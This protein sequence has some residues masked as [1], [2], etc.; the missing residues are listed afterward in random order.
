[1]TW[2]NNGLLRTLPEKDAA[3][4]RSR[5]ELVTLD[6]DQ[7][8]FESK[9]PI[10]N[11]YFFESGLSSEVVFATKS[12]EVG[13]IGHEGC[14]GVPVLLGVD[15]SPH[16]AFMQA[17]GTALRIASADLTELIDTNRAIRELLLRYAH[18][19]MIQIA[20]TALADGRYDIEQRLARWLLM[21]QDRLGD[22][23]PLTHDFLSVMLGVR[24]PSVTDAL[25]KLEGNRAIRAER[26]LITVRD[27]AALEEKAGDSY[28]IP[29]AEYRRLISHRENAQ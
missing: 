4:V 25:H 8:L 29:E 2:T 10:T 15:S 20:A 7:T 13:C 28:G 3:L 1:M 14:S 12:I 6:Q 5:A 24:R 18:V 21:C 11:V 16:K 17:G 9:K 27:R 19:F 26:A 22:E 23:L